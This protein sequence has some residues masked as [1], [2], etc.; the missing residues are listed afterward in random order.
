MIVDVWLYK[1][2]DGEKVHS[3]SLPTLVIPSLMH[4]RLRFS[5]YNSSNDS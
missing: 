5:L 4:T 1:N 3:T 2:S